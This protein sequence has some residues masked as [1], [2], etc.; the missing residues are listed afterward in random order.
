M[1]RGIRRRNRYDAGVLETRTP[2]SGVA[3]RRLAA[4]DHAAGARQRARR[5]PGRA[6]SVADGSG[7][8]R[9]HRRAAPAK[10]VT[11]NSGWRTAGAAVLLI[12]TVL[13]GTAA[14]QARGAGPRPGEVETAP[15]R[16]WWKTDRTSIRVGERF[17]LTLTCSVIETR[18]V[19]VVPTLT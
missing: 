16:C 4:G 10:D 17:G 9:I 3:R 13:G 5:G 12:G 8:R 1:D 19:T 7:A 14:G 6:R 18:S 11:M 2:P 15:I